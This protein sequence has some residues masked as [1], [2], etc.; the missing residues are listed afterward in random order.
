MPA[1]RVETLDVGPRAAWN[2][3]ELLGTAYMCRRE[4]NLRRG[5]LEPAGSVDAR[6]TV[7]KGFSGKALKAALSP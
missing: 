2:P 7:R 4:E 5:L 1:R 6:S 3:L